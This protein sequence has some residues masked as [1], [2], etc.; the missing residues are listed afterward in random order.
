MGLILALMGKDLLEPEI[1]HQEYNRLVN[2]VESTKIKHCLG[3]KTQQQVARKFSTL[4]S[5]KRVF[6]KLMK[7]QARLNNGE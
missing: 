3:K 6:E 2:L 4:I 1:L 7:E 5:S